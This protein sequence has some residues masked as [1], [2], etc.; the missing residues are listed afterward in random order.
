MILLDHAAV[1]F[2]AQDVLTFLGRQLHGRFQA[3]V[4]T[5]CQKD[6]PSARSQRVSRPEAYPTF[7]GSAAKCCTRDL[8][9]VASL[10]TGANSANSVSIC[11]KRS[12]TCR[13]RLAASVS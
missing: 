5:Q 12:A 13:P 9:G 2:P 7:A 8:A 11:S 3:E 6:R 1:H 4:L 10:R